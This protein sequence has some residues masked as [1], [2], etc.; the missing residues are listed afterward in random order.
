M[1]T[2]PLHSI[3]EHL[4][5]ELSDG[6]WFIDTGADHSLGPE[7]HTLTLGAATTTTRTTYLGASLKA[8]QR[9]GELPAFRGLLGQDLL[10]RN[11]ILFDLPAGT[12]TIYSESAT[13]LSGE[14]WLR[15]DTAGIPATW[16]TTDDGYQPWWIDT[17]AQL[18]YFRSPTWA[19]PEKRLDDAWDFFPLYGRFKT[20]TYQLDLP[21]NGAWDTLRAG[22]LPRLL[23]TMLGTRTAGIIGQELFRHRAIGFFPLQGTLMLGRRQETTA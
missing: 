4:F 16:L 22:R 9:L 19:R 17:G 1:T 14:A 3:K 20:P 6:M 21:F 5:F 2:I 18:S 23:S 15:M 10:M 11:D 12:A 13:G 7:G 8:I